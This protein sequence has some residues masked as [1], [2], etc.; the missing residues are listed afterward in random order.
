MS[1]E[2][3]ALA[4]RRTSFVS[5]AFWKKSL[6]Q[7]QDEIHRDV[8]VRSLSLF[9]LIMIGIGGT[10]G[11]G[12][13]ATA[14]LIAR[15]YAGPAAVLSWILA[16]IGCVLTGCAFMELSGLIPTHGSTYAYAYHALGEY[17]AVIAGFLLTLE[18]GIACAG[19]ARAWSA[20]F[21]V[22]IKLMF[23]IDGPTWMKPP[24]TSIDLYACALMTVCVLVVCAGMAIGKRLIN[25]ITLTKIAVVLFIIVAG[26]TQFHVEYLDPFLPPST[27]NAATGQVVFGW[28]GVMVGASASFYGYIGYDEVC[29]LAGEAVNP[30]KNIPRAVLGTVIGAAILSIMATLSVMGMQRYNLIDVHES[31]GEAFKSVGY[32]W[33]SPIVETGEVLTMPVGILIGFLAQPRVQCAMATDGLLPRFLGQL[34]ASGNPRVGTVVAG[35]ILI[36]LATFVEFQVLWNFISLGILLAFN[37][38]NV[39]L[40]VVRYGPAPTLHVRSWQLQLP[41][42]LT[43]FGLTSFLSALHWQ[44]GAI[45]PVVATS[46]GGE[47]YAAYMSSAGVPI[48]AVCS[49]AMVAAMGILVGNPPTHFEDE[50]LGDEGKGLFHCPAVPYVPCIAI[51]FNWLL[52]VQMPG[53]T[54]LMMAAWILFATITYVA[55]GTRHG[56]ASTTPSA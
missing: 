10:V 55:Y 27:V 20:K 25:V 17:P 9:D 24:G 41:F 16:G 40:L 47:A 45:A 6:A 18:Y 28:P 50:D 32:L 43:L 51:Y 21:V 22:W 7:L 2:K 37:M 34:D 42:V 4:P 31:Y 1:L 52:A 54:V 30:R 53:H 35:V 15:C 13:F 23:N 29:C 14:G 56:L 3:A 5:R 19:N 49:V 46:R 26:L 39:S 12:V 38:T 11:S 8:H 44:H 48:A 36:T 33:A